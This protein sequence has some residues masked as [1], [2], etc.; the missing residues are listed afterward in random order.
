MLSMLAIGTLA[1]F[2]SA[3]NAKATVGSRE[4]VCDMC[5]NYC[6]IEVAGGTDAD[7]EDCWDG[8]DDD[9]YDYYYGYD[10][11]DESQRA[12]KQAQIKGRVDKL[13]VK[14]R[15]DCPDP[16]EDYCWVSG[17]FDNGSGGVSTYDDYDECLADCEADY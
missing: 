15:V 12:D 9:Y 13:K 5:Y 3:S 11:D 14:Q 1:L 4:D 2:A 6:S 17:G 8:C 10:R 16:C 7:Y